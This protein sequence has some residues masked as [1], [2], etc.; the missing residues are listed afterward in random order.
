MS[1]DRKLSC[2]APDQRL[3]AAR[4]KAG[5]FMPY[6]TM[7]IQSLIPHPAPGLGTL[8]VTQGNHLLVDYDALGEWTAP[9]AGAVLIHEWMHR[10]GKH[11]ERFL[12]LISAGAADPSD[13]SDWNTACDAEINCS[14]VEANLPLPGEFV[15]PAS[16]NMPPHRLAEEYFFELKKRRAENPSSCPGL[17]PP[18]GSGVA[19]PHSRAPQE[20]DTQEDPGRTTAEQDVQRRQ[21]SEQIQSAAKTRGNVPQDLLR[22][23]EGELAPP[24]VNWDTKL[25]VATRNL[26]NRIAGEQE[27]AFDVRSRMQDGL[28]M[29]L[30]EEDTPYLPGFDAHTAEVWF[31]VDTSGS[32]TPKALKRVASEARSVLEHMGGARITFAAI[33]A[34]VHVLKPIASLDEL[35]SNL[36]GGGGTDFR[37]LFAAFE[38]AKVKPDVIIFAT[39]GYGPAPAEEPSGVKTI[40][41]V[42]DG[43]TP[44]SWGESIHISTQDDLGLGDDD[45]DLDLS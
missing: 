15:T 35:W 41:L 32:V 24:K 19:G 29:S 36:R 45:E 38:E 12:K 6:F 7:G 39:D 4:V 3:S 13:A 23:A 25:S 31:A 33:D 43:Q 2:L 10:Y 18:E 16:I 30:G 26:V 28:A 5:V 42:I 21:T 22:Q 20:P 17:R 8:G 9:E 14:L 1:S 44:A 34:K 40:W 27:Y 37:P 11:A